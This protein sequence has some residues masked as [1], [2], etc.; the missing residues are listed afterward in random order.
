MKIVD[1]IL[2]EKYWQIQ[3]EG[4]TNQKKFPKFRLLFKTKK[5]YKVAPGYKDSDY[6]REISEVEEISSG[7]ILRLR[8]NMIALPCECGIW[9]LQVESGGTSEIVKSAEHLTREMIL[10]S[11]R[12]LF[13]GAIRS[14]MYPVI[15]DSSEFYFEQMVS[16]IGGIKSQDTILLHYR[17]EGERLYLALEE[18]GP[19]PEIRLFFRDYE[20]NRGFSIPVAAKA[21]RI[22][23]LVIV[24]KQKEYQRDTDVWE[25]ECDFVQSGQELRQFLDARYQVGIEYWENGSY[26]YRRVRVGEFR[27]HRNTGYGI[28]D[29]AEWNMTVIPYFKTGGNFGVYLADNAD[30][31]YYGYLLDAHDTKLLHFSRIYQQGNQL[32]IEVE[33]SLASDIVRAQV[34]CMDRKNK[35]LV[36]EEVDIAR[37]K[38]G[39][40]L[41]PLDE[42]LK[43]QERGKAGRR[44]ILYLTVYQKEEMMVYHLTD[45]SHWQEKEDLYDNM[46][47]YYPP[48]MLSEV[49]TKEGETYQVSL[50]PYLEVKNHYLRILLLPK[51][52][53]YLEQQE[54]V[55]RNIRV[56]RGKLKLT[57]T[58]KDYG[59]YPETI[60]IQLRSNVVEK[61]YC[62][63]FS[64]H[65]FPGK[66][67]WI[68]ASID[69]ENV[70]FE[71]FYWDIAGT[72]NVNGDSYQMR[73]TNRNKLLSRSLYL[74]HMEYRRGDGFI[75]Y[76]YRKK[77]KEFALYYR[78]RTPYDRRI[79]VWKEYLALACNFLFKSY[80]HR[81]NIWL[82][83]EKYCQ[84]AQDNGY[85]FFKYCMEHLPEAEKRHIYY[86][87]DKN[88]A[89]YS[90]VESYGKQVIP[91][92]SFKHM[93]YLQ[94][95]RVLI[96]SD[97]KAH[98]YA[99]H[100]ANSVYRNSLYKKKNVFLQ[101]GVMAFK[102]CHKGL[103]KGSANPSSLF[104][105]SSEA[106]ADIIEKYF[107]YSPS[108]IAITGLA[109]W[110]VLHDKSDPA[111]REILLMPTWRTWL[112]EVQKEDFIQSDYYRHY[113]DFLNQPQLEEL[114][115]NYN[116]TMN[117]YIHPK[118]REYLE[119]FSVDSKRIHLIPFGSE[120][121]NELI[122]RCSMMITDYSSACWDVYYQGKPVLFYLFDLE[123]YNEVQ[124]SYINME[125]EAFGDSARDGKTLLDLMEYYIRNNFKEKDQ[126]AEQRKLLLPYR[127]DLNSKRTYDVIKKKG[128]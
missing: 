112:E 46:K 61:R 14:Y 13:K 97:T 79:F 23:N 64:I 90:V 67:L 118:F 16:G 110:D 5:S 62:M 127:D 109:R 93:V 99:W 20:N 70:E 100:S 122:M 105:T 71:Q 51:E 65:H 18:S 29:L 98:A 111:H 55:V 91:F 7:Y 63:N 92:L 8:Q 108:E 35:V 77:S 87:I 56:V 104:I 115:E 121:L 22:P 50:L 124:G 33:Q 19:I 34:A 28:A 116:I 21:V 113:M 107:E 39:Q 88:A 32:E 82:V 11:N 27:T 48:M 15:G 42:L 106:E 69:L 68:Q 123:L 72:W 66:T 57:I 60:Y 80:L 78:L 126:Y 31:D 117:F 119:E 53:A 1:V 36:T 83:Y 81:K 59:I 128:W 41:I 114:L 49:E 10:E 26:R 17:T 52:S 102:C 6:N 24:E 101:H 3:V 25:L 120:P 44:Y 86:V 58:M 75:A 38:Q 73:L 9:H 74:R 37:L 4:E 89:D 125:T 45:Q 43:F 47:R 76:P 96:S 95:A 84:M 94:A 40:L 2:L 85:Y 30:R 54:A 12:V 103:R